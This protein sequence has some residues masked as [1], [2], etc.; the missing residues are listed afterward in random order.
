MG[1]Y[2]SADVLCPYYIKD[3]PKPCSLICESILPNG[4][5]KTYFAGR[6]EMQELMGKYCA[7]DYSQCRWYRT[8][9]RVVEED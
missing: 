2:T 5:I 6:A 1:T 7:G 8:L 4:R 9:S 3:V